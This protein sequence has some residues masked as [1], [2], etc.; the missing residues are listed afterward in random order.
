MTTIGVIRTCNSL[1]SAYYCPYVNGS[2][3]DEVHAFLKT[4][5]IVMPNLHVKSFDTY[6]LLDLFP[7]DVHVEK[8]YGGLGTLHLFKVIHSLPPPGTRCEAPPQTPP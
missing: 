1:G 3:S 7:G 5:G 8:I 6:A 4:K 2:L